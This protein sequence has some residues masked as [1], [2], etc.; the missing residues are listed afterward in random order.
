[1]LS[2]IAVVGI[3]PYPWSDVKKVLMFAA[4]S[5]IDEMLSSGSFAE[6]EVRAAAESKQQLLHAL[7][8]KFSALP[9]TAQRFCEI[10]LNV[11]KFYSTPSKLAYA[12][13]K[14][15]R[16][17]HCSPDLSPDEFAA[18]FAE[19]KRAKEELPPAKPLMMA[20]DADMRVPMVMLGEGGWGVQSNA[21]QHSNNMDVSD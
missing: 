21:P 12:L 5:V 17:T 8:S 11:R 1:V 6:S 10:L 18:R 16:V 7:S 2:T 3:S 13:E 4:A 15:L 20:I 14:L 19:L 9:F